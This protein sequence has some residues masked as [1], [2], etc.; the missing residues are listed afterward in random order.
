MRR[1]IDSRARASR[2]EAKLHSSVLER[3][4]RRLTTDDSADQV[5][6]VEISG[7]RYPI[8]TG[9]DP[10]Y[11]AR[12]AAYVDERMRAVGEVTPTG[13][14]VRLAVLAALNIADEL[15]RCRDSSRA[16][17][18]EIAERAHELEE[19]LDRVLMAS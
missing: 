10:E 16:R 7:Q 4:R 12:I 13:D 18:G 3:A 2:L 14:P 6:S 17:S 1:R 9:L 11:V 8:R 15:F 5:V 19:L